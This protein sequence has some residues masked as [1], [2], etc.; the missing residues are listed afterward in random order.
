MSTPTNVSS[1]RLSNPHLAVDK[2]LCISIR[3]RDD[4]R[5]KLMEETSGLGLDIEFVLTDKD[6]ENPER[7]CF[8]AHRQCA[9]IALSRG[10]QRILILEDDARRE[11]NGSV[12]QRIRAINRFLEQENPEIFYLG[13]ILGKAWLTARWRILGCSVYGGHAYI[14]SRT[15]CER[16]SN[17]DYTGEAIDVFYR[18]TLTGHAIFP[19]IF[20]QWP[21]S[22]FESD[23]H[24]ERLKSGNP[25]VMD[26]NYWAKQRRKLNIG[27]IIKWSLR[28]HLGGR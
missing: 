3:E 23:I 5:A 2:T 9:E 24:L 28:H 22:Q 27:N 14:L 15:S 7:G 4:R 12:F 8:R 1:P 16:L 25:N 13:Y 20:S 26:E 6:S 10:Y 21:C 17:I 18:K 11:E 19:P